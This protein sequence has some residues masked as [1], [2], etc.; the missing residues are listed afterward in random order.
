MRLAIARGVYPRAGVNGRRVAMRA[1]LRAIGRVLAI[2]SLA[3]LLAACMKLD[4]ELTVKSDDTV[5]G[6]LIFAVQQSVLDMT[7]G[8]IDD[9]TSDVEGLPATAK[10]EPWEEDEW[11][12]Q[13][14]TFDAMPLAEFNQDS[15]LR[16][17]REGDKFVVSGSMDLSSGTGTTGFEGAEDLMSSAEIR[18]KLTFPGKVESGTGSISGNSITWTPKMGENTPIEAVASAIDSGGGI[19]TWLLLGG[20][21]IV[22]IIVV[23]MVMSKRGG[24]A[25]AVA[26]GEVGF[27]GAPVGDV[28]PTP[29]APAP[30]APAAPVAPAMPV[31]P[32]PSPAGDSGDPGGESG[33][34]SGGD[35]DPN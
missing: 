35:S 22:V 30:E 27:T 23:A 17:V 25:P 32:E 3:V 15:D 34:D 4:M 33:G 8:S 1:R 18:V 13:K 5:D 24:A 14:Y 9:F 28:A 12:G 7:G 26:G 31:E 10:V 19:T 29:E 11:V 20:G 16:I 2:G 21:V 6:T